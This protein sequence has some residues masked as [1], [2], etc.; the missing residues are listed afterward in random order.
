MSISPE[1]DTPSPEA[2]SEVDRA[3]ATL[4]LQD[5][6]DAN[7]LDGVSAALARGADVA[8]RPSAG[9]TPLVVAP[10]AQRPAIAPRLLAAG[11]AP[12]PP[13]A[14]HASASPSAAAAGLN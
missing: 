10:K 13:D 9:R 12:A 3:A 4:A 7:D 14:T 1:S 6:V 5:A 11:A 8:V 2:V